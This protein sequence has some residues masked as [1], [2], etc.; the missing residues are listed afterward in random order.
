MP[1]TDRIL[2]PTS[3]VTLSAFMPKYLLISLRKSG[4]YTFVML[5]S[6]WRTKC[7]RFCSPCDAPGCLAG[8]W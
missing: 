2:R 5:S 7:E 4:Y 8:G 3:S 6:S 1:P